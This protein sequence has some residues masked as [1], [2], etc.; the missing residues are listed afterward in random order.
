MDSELILY[1][2]YFDSA[3]RRTEGR[4]VPLS[5]AVE[6][7]SI[8]GIRKALERLGVTSATE[9]ASHPGHWLQRE[10]RVRVGYQ[11]TKAELLR[12]VA[13]QLSGGK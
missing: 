1:P 12:K 7:P 11:G 10:G 5:L 9:A 2:C 8:T 6:H 13:S 4:R 3:L